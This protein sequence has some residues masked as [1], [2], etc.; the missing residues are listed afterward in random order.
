MCQAPDPSANK[1]DQRFCPLGT[2][3]LAGTSYV[4]TE[5]TMEVFAKREAV[6]VARCGW[7]CGVLLGEAG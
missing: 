2:G 7:I 4:A 6:Q 3:S 5:K 1:A